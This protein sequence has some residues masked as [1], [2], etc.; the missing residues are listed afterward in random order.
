MLRK[1]IARRRPR[2]RIQTRL[3]SSLKEYNVDQQKLNREALRLRNEAWYL[4]NRPS[5]LA[6]HKGK[7][8]IVDKEQVIRAE[9]TYEAL[10]NFLGKPET[11]P[12]HAQY[13]LTFCGFED[14][15][16]SV[17]LQGQEVLL[18]DF[19]IKGPPKHKYE[20]Q[21]MEVFDPEGWFPPTETGHLP[22]PYITLPVKT[23]WEDKFVYPVSF[24]VDT[25]TSTTYVSAETISTL[26]IGAS[27]ETI[28]TRGIG[29]RKDKVVQDLGPLIVIDEVPIPLTKST[30][31]FPE[32]NL[33]GNDYIYQ[34]LLQV[35]K[36]RGA[37][38]ITK[39]D[40]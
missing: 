24:L 30:G 35:A 4:E 23:N 25:G 29:A 18:Q 16:P 7:F 31:H 37:L 38:L 28:S 15:Q 34:R 1:L 26:G 20:Y 22:R 21:R 2:K 19:K 13:Y 11:R 3:Q 27:A 33:L 6:K 40:L 5:L 14:Y 32:I 17:L 36:F 39:P 9:D 8:V 12:N 10:L